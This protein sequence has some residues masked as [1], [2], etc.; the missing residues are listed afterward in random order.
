MSYVPL[1]VGFSL[2]ASTSGGVKTS[3]TGIPVKT[4]SVPTNVT[5]TTTCGP[6]YQVM[7]RADGTS[8]CA[9]DAE[10]ARLRLI[11][12]VANAVAVADAKA[13]A[14]LALTRNIAKAIA[15][16]EAQR[17]AA[18]Q[19]G[20][21]IVETQAGMSRNTKLLWAAGALVV[22]VAVVWALK[23]KPAK[24]AQNAGRKRKN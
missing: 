1:G 20:V 8:Y 9:T 23:R 2:E 14:K 21:V 5:A 4:V 17:Q 13:K 19:G 18:T 22:G 16:I 7:Q 12:N 3:A 15:Q 6:G 11:K 10:V 24:M